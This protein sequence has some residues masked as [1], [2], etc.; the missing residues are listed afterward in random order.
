ME[1]TKNILQV[2]QMYP[3]SGNPQAGRIYDKRGI[4]PSLDTCQGGN[5]MPKIVAS[6]G[7]YILENGER[8][9]KQQLE[10]NNT[11]NTNA[12]TT[13]Q[14]DNYV[15]DEQFKFRKLTPKEC[16]RLMGFDDNDI[17]ILIE[18]K[19]SNTQL[20]KMVGNS[21]CVPVIESIFKNLYIKQK[22]ARYG[23]I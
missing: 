6:R 18:N 23:N 9:I 1:N 2:A 4:S 22:G 7:R 13:V 11:G 12:L 14:K 5:R 19:I 15:L 10:I 17:N 8:R 3:N 16:F 21:I 20:Y